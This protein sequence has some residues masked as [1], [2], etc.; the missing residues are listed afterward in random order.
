MSEE[1]ISVGLLNFIDFNYKTALENFNKALQKDENNLDAILYRGIC[2]LKLG[3]YDQAISDLNKAES[4]SSSSF[5]ISYNRG[6]S[7]L[8]NCEINYAKQDLEQAKKLAN[9]DQLLIVTK[10]LEKLN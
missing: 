1:F 7:Y 3:N 4:Q 5:E 10:V 8:Y 9:D 6:I 2:N